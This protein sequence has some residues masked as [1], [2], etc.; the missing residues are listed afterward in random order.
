MTRE[1][2]DFNQKFVANPEIVVSEE[3]DGALLFDPQTGAIKL[4]NTTGFFIYN[5]LNGKN[6]I[7]HILEEMVKGFN[8]IQREEA[9]NDL[10]DFIEQMRKMNFIGMKS[11]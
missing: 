11:D 3:D 6:S 5:R 2:L 1:E 8:G 10:S 7:Y 4:I 9:E